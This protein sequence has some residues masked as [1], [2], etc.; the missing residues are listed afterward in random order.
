MDPR[1]P[2]RIY[3]G[4]FHL[5][6]KTTDGGRDWNPIH[7]GMIDDS[8]VL[9][10]LIDSVDPERVYSSACS[11]IYRSD[12]GG[13]IWKKIQG[14]PYTAR[15]T[16]VIRQDPQ[17][18]ATLFAGTSE[19]LW[20]TTDAGA[21]WRRLT[22][23][24]WVIN[25]LAFAS[26]SDG[27]RR[28]LL[29]TE[30]RGVLA[31]DDGGEK[32]RAANSGFNHREI[33]A[34]GSDPEN[35]RRILVVLAHAPESVLATEDG[36]ATW[37]PLGL[38]LEAQTLKRLYVSPDGWWAALERG[39]LARYDA[40]KGQWTRAGN[41][42]GAI[43]ETTHANSRARK[44]QASSGTRRFDFVVNDM[45]FARGVWFA[46]TDEGLFASHDE[47]AT[48]RLYPFAPLV[49][50]VR[51]VAVAPDGTQIK[52]VSLRGMVFSDD[53]GKTWSWHDL[54]AEAGGAL[55]ILVAQGSQ[56]PALLATSPAGL[57]VSRDAGRTWKRSAS[58]LPQTG[59][60]D[61]AAS[62]AAWLASMETGGLYV[63]YD[64]G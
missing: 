42:A 41:T 12:D 27:V 18:P 11:G 17:H 5:P 7:A 26:A 37:T 6:W 15:R 48:W 40:A 33:V 54:P 22:P 60:A 28:L 56:P 13:A 24:D 63:S 59:I 36:G 55:R 30:E 50:P 62:P 58:G 10:I 9:T 31:S 49:L 61:I 32:F 23:S 16:Y 51:S 43:Q 47:G 34:L 46:A 3:A 38:G 52:I 39:G 57:Y 20:R 44:Q 2:Q 53:A 1:D 64:A 45:A 29:G 25:T 35:S 21:D 8:D 19:G 4:T 14:I